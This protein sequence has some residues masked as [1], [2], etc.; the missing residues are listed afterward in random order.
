[1]KKIM[2]PNVQCPAHDIQGKKTM[3]C[4]HELRIRSNNLFIF[5]ITFWKS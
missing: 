5:S 4:G 2:K 3:Y 1:M